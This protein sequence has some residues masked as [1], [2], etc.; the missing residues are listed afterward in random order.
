MRPVIVFLS[1]PPK[2]PFV[3]V[4]RLGFLL[5]LALM[6]ASAGLLATRGLN[7]GIDFRGGIVMEVKTQSGPAHLDEMRSKLNALG[8]GEVSLQSFGAANDV[9]I[10][11]PRQPGGDAAQNRAAEMA[12]AALGSGYD[13]RRTEVVGPKVGGEL[14]HAGT[15]ATVL[16]TLAIAGYVWF[17]F[18]WQFGV[19]AVFSLFHDV[20]TALGLFSAL[21]LEF[22]LA[23]LAAILTIAGYSINDKVVIFDR[24]R[25]NLRKYKVMALP[26]LLDLS[27]N[28]TLSRTLMTSTVTAL[29]VLALLIFGG[30]VIRGFSAAMLWGI[31][32]GTYSSLFLAAP[33][34]LYVKPRRAGSKAVPAATPVPGKAR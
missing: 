14:I 7:F 27:L 22:N 33:L 32:A 5:S 24:V 11:L 28:E 3:R 20:F 34:L 15:I 8:L 6:L 19:G 26:D 21:Q 4:H 16:A 29:A 30:A 12:R 17:R 31:V 9:L 18:E 2:F 10:R 25:E 1:K 13:Y 23:T